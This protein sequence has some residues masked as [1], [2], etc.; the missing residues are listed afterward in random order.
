MSEEC[1]LARDGRPSMATGSGT[2]CGWCELVV[3]RRRAEQTHVAA[4][5]ASVVARQVLVLMRRGLVPAPLVCMLGLLRCALVR[6]LARWTLRL[7]RDER[8]YPRIRC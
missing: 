7:E 8:A 2:N 3:E 1:A 5:A 4:D 6:G